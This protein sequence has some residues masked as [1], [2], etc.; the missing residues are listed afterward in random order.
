MRNSILD[1]VP[2]HLTCHGV[3]SEPENLIS[4]SAWWPGLLQYVTVRATVAHIFKTFMV[5]FTTSPARIANLFVLDNT[6]KVQQSHSIQWK[7]KQKKPVFLQ[8]VV[9]RGLCSADLGISNCSRLLSL[10]S[11]IKDKEKLM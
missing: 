3:E 2:L 8:K 10:E 11:G 4:L 1:V 7:A 9:N 6:C 5:V